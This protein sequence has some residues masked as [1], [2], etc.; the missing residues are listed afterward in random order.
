MALAVKFEMV[1]VPLVVF[2]PA[3]PPEAEQE[4][5]PVED[6]VSVAE[7]PAGTFVALEE[8]E[9]V[10]A[11]AGAVGGAKT[12]GTVGVRGVGDVSATG[13]GAAVPVPMPRNG[14]VSEVPCAVSMKREPVR[15][16]EAVGRKNTLI[17]QRSLRPRENP[18]VLT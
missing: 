14:T 4:V 15:A 2:V 5:A 11:G 7:P 17:R 1:C 8:N 13:V 9:I 12:V 3:Q 6:Q 18:Q 10:G 16:P